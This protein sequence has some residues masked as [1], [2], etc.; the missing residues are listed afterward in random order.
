MNVKPYKM[1]EPLYAE[2]YGDK[3]GPSYIAYED[4]VPGI[5]VVAREAGFVGG[6]RIRSGTAFFLPLSLLKPMP[7]D[8]P[9]EPEYDFVGHGEPAKYYIVPDWVVL[10][11]SL[12][13]AKQ[14]VANEQP[15]REKKFAE[16]AIHA[17]GSKGAARRRSFVEEIRRGEAAPLPR[18]AQGAIDASGGAA[19]KAKMTELRK[20]ATQADLPIIEDSPHE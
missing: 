13:H 6:R 9:E 4:G 15:A 18:A 10:G 2:K 19:A 17:S 1:S 11:N 8:A 16:G 12:E 3:D 5:R 14:L 20:Q 7:P